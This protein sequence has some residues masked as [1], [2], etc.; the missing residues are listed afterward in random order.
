MAAPIVERLRLGPMDNFLYLV[1]DPDAAV[2]AIVDAGW[3]PERIQAAA[4]ARGCTLDAILLTHAHYDHA[5]QAVRLARD[6]GATI[7]VHRA[8]ATKL[9]GQGVPVV[10]TEE[11]TEISLGG[12]RIVCLHT[13]GHTPGSQ[14]FLLG[15]RLFSGDTLFVNACG[16]VDLAGGDEAQMNASLRR[17]AGLDP[18]VVVLPGHDYGPTPTS[19]I[20]EQRVSNPFLRRA[21]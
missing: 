21:R 2:C 12:Q 3:E 14:S 5:Q 9:Q 1:A 20:G 19:T 7:Y 11:G 6:T 4:R 13:P 8:E 17:L 16:R 10:T 15:G 18:A